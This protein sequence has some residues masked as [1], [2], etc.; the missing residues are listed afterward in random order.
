[1]KEPAKSKSEKYGD[2]FQE[3]L[4]EEYKMY[5]EMMDRVTERRGKANMFYT[6]LLSTLLALASFLTENKLIPDSNKLL[7]L[8]AILGLILCMI[9][10]TNI[11]SYKQLNSLKFK[12]IEEIEKNL[13]F[14]CYVREWQIDKTRTRKYRRLT[15]VEKYLPLILGIPYLLLL[16]YSI[17]SW[18]PKNCNIS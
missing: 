11:N 13:P 7:F 17:V 1:M 8:F 10:Y 2:K 9:W 14:P 5:V 18:L 15:Q 3:H 6:T 4:L 16:V 12:V